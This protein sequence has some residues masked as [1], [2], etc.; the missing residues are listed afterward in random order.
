MLMS[1][2]ISIVLVLRG[3]E[4]NRRLLVYIRITVVV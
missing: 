4:M 1:I 2:D 3:A